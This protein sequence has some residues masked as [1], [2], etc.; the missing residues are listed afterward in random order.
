MTI[1]KYDLLEDKVG[2]DILKNAGKVVLL[3]KT[4]ELRNKE[5]KIWR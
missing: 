5:N 1:Y 3:Y 2:D 4:T